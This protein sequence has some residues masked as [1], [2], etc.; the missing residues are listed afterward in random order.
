MR[1]YELGSIENN[2]I[3]KSFRQI[4]LSITAAALSKYPTV[5]PQLKEL[6]SI[7]EIPE[8]IEE[9]CFVVVNLSKKIEKGSHW[10]AIHSH[11]R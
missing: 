7:D 1:G 6:T 4:M 11:Q 3:K 5:Y 10:I 8:R 9:N 2:V